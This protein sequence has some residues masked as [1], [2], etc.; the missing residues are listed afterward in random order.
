M[1]PRPPRAW[2]GDLPIDGKATITH[3]VAV[4]NNAVTTTDGKR[5]SKP[6][7]ARRGVAHGSGRQ[8]GTSSKAGP[9]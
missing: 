6:L 1:T 9:R 8:S 3:S 5:G 2:K 4:H 7:T